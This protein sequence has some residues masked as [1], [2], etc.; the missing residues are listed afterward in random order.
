MTDTVDKLNAIYNKHAAKSGGTIEGLFHNALWQVM[1]NNSLKGAPAAFTC[2]DSPYQGHI[3]I[4]LDEGGYITSCC[5][6][7]ANLTEE[8]REEVLAD[9]NKE[10]FG[11]L[12]DAADNII[13]RSLRHVQSSR[14]EDRENK[15]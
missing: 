1:I 5:G 8:D 7:V 3:I 10:V 15:S 13:L 4:A 9:L 12:R 2:I 14:K 6:F 11:L